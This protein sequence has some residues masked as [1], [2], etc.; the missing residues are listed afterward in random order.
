MTYREQEEKR[1]IM[2]ATKDFVLF[3]GEKKC[4]NST[5]FSV[6][7]ATGG[8]WSKRG[9]LKLYNDKAEKYANRP[10]Y[11]FVSGYKN[12]RNDKYLNSLSS[13]F[14]SYFSFERCGKFVYEII[15]EIICDLERKGKFA[16]AKE[17]KEAA[18]CLTLEQ[19]KQI[20]C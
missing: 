19:A 13:I 8:K 20:Y 15:G 10:I 14:Y 2:A 17:L 4:T 18:N 9:F 7:E 12:I 5:W 16:I 6:T 3:V 11:W 1:G